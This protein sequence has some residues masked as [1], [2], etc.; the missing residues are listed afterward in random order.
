M[1]ESNHEANMQLSKQLGDKSVQPLTK[2]ERSV[3]E[4]GSMFAIAPTK[5]PYVQEHRCRN[6]G[7][8]WMSTIWK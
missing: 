2:S 1:E 6:W 7:I 3:L 5:I 8:D 4:K